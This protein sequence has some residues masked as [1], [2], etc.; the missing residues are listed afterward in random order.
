[1]LFKF[2][3]SLISFQYSSAYKLIYVH[4]RVRVACVFIL[5]VTRL[6]FNCFRFG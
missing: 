4:V 3:M 5:F 2:S 1:M 6:C